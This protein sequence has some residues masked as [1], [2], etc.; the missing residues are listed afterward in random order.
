MFVVTGLQLLGAAGDIVSAAHKAAN[1]H[2]KESGIEH[3]VY[4]DSSA[5]IP[6]SHYV[7][8]MHVVLIMFIGPLQICSSIILKEITGKVPR[9]SLLCN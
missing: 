5:H 2:R 8:Y 6:F 1:K 9:L 3:S 7:C 4:S